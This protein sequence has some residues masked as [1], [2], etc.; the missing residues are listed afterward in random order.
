LH[1]GRIS[2]LRADHDRIRGHP[3]IAQKPRERA[4]AGNLQ[5]LPAGQIVG[6][7]RTGEGGEF[8]LVAQTH[9]APA[10]RPGDTE[11]QFFPVGPD[12][13]GAGFEQLV[14]RQPDQH[15]AAGREEFD[16]RQRHRDLEEITH[17]AVQFLG[18][19]VFANACGKFGGIGDVEDFGGKS[20]QQTTHHRLD[21]IILQCCQ[22]V[23]QHEKRQQNQVQA[24]EES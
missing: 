15:D 2:G 7:E 6:Q 17:F 21:A 1:F 12:H 16:A 22:C 13:R 23:E 9:D 18:R 3:A 4:C 8:E 14:R 10:E 11:N 20:R 24:Q 5:N 19:Q